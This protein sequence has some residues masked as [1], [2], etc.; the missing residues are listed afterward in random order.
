LPAPNAISA[1]AI[2]HRSVVRRDC[3]AS[4]RLMLL[5]AMYAKITVTMTIAMYR[6][7][8]WG[9]VSDRLCADGWASWL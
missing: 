2:H 5:S 1:A 6:I 8:F 7:R 4:A 9:P 3:Q